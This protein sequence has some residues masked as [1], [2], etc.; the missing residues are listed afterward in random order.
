M[1]TISVYYTVNVFLERLPSVQRQPA[2]Y[3]S[4]IKSTLRIQYVNA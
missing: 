4:L 2:L 3:V 1:Y